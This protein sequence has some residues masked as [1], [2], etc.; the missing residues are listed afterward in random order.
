MFHKLIKYSRSTAGELPCSQCLYGTGIVAEPHKLPPCREAYALQQIDS[1][2]KLLPVHLFFTA[3]EGCFFSSIGWNWHV[4][5]KDLVDISRQ[6]T[7]AVWLIFLT[8]FSHF[9]C[10]YTILLI[11]LFSFHDCQSPLFIP[12]FLL[13]IDF[14][15]EFFN[16]RH[17]NDFFPRLEKMLNVI[18][19]VLRRS[20][21]PF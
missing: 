19:C 12:F 13:L 14:L 4:T 10:N 9:E 5:E 1:N 8:G 15:F 18:R 21:S 6:L 2:N 16:F 3:L 11:F 20:L 17:L 7:L